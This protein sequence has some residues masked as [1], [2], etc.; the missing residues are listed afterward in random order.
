MDYYLWIK[1]GHIISVIAWMV[2][3]LYLPRLF[4]YHASVEAGSETCSMLKVMERR[5]LRFIMNPA[6][7]VSFALGGCM[8]VLNPVLLE[9]NWMQ[10][11]ILI[12]VL[13][14]GI[15]AM[16]ARW[17]RFFE[18]NKNSLSPKFYRVMNESPTVLLVAIV[19]LAVVKPE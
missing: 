2:G 13:M 8:L 17:R 16:L 15:H 9:E 5:L 3:L 6:M 11:K 7:A 4:V 18:V 1:A 10:Y 14:T 19:I 12:L